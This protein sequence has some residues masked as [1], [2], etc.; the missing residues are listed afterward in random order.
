MKDAI[1]QRTL[2]LGFDDC[3]FTSAAAP[4]SAGKFQ[5]WLVQKKHGEMQWLE[6]NAEK[7]GEPQHVYPMRKA[8][9]SSRRA[10]TKPIHNP[11]FTIHDRV[12]LPATPASMTTTT[13]SANG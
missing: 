1:R 5:D 8:L 4:A 7:R 2:E 9:L 11:R 6:R 12:K 10:I 13:F 3:R